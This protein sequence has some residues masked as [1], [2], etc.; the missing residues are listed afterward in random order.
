VGRLV[1]KKGLDAVLRAFAMVRSA[2]PDAEL[3]IVGDGPLR[4]LLPRSGQHSD[5][6]IWHG[7]QTPDRVRQIMEG[8]RLLT[9]PSR[10]VDD[11][12]AEG[13]G[14]V[15]IE[16]QALGI[17]VVTSDRGGTLEAVLPGV[18]GLAVDPTSATALADAFLQLLNDPQRAAS[19]GTSARL[20]VQENFDIRQQAR[21]LERIY[22]ELSQGSETARSGA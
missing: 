6:V 12:D 7:A 4:R 16:A 1:A 20:W 18:T 19:M 9:L 15:L 21:A 10:Q 2:R 14:L 5:G 3:H 11:G 13:F 17:P 22:D 8:A